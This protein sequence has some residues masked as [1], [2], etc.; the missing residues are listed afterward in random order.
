M[1]N[2]N[3]NVRKNLNQLHK[4]I[5]A[6]NQLRNMFQSKKLMDLGLYERASILQQP[7]TEAI[8]EQGKTISKASEDNKKDLQLIKNNN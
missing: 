8:V 5:Q 6:K 7:T 1:Y 4:T 2:N 3:I